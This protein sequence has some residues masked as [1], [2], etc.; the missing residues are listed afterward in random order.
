M[1]ENKHIA[2]RT[3]NIARTNKGTK[4]ELFMSNILLITE[5][6]HLMGSKLFYYKHKQNKFLKS[7][8]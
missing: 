2:N 1:N 8:Q 3:K 4:T 7:S 6:K 5:V